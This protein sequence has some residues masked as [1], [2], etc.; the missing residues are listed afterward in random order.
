MSGYL[1]KT[2]LNLPPQTVTLRCACGWYMRDVLVSEA[3]RIHTEHL[4]RDRH[5][6]RNRKSGA[7]AKSRDRLNGH[8]WAVK[9]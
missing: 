2:K 3:T 7:Q 9:A 4:T 6:G 5:T 1:L 8:S